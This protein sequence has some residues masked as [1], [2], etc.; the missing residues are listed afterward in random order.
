MFD[1]LEDNKAVR[2]KAKDGRHGKGQSQHSLALHLNSEP[3]RC[4]KNINNVFR[5]ALAPSTANIPKNFPWVVS[6]CE[7]KNFFS[8]LIRHDIN[9]LLAF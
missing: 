2:N 6:T 4:S 8:A 3:L 1:F 9:L 5:S 7:I